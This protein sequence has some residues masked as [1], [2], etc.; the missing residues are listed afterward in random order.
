V[1]KPLDPVIDELIDGLTD[2]ILDRFPALL[3]APPALVSVVMGVTQGFF[4][5]RLMD[6]GMTPEQIAHALRK[7][8]KERQ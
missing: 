2:D 6:N 3:R 1:D 4:L 5:K 8:E 7:P